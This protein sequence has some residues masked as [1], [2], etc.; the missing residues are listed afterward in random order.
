[1]LCGD[2]S[3]NVEGVK[4]PTKSHWKTPPNFTE[5]TARELLSKTTDYEKVVRDLYNDDGKFEQN[6]K[7]LWILRDEN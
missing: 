7:L 5:A 3:D 2:K 4:N 1:M 6:K